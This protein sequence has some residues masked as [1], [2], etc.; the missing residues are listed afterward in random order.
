MTRKE[1]IELAE[2]ETKEKVVG[3][4][5]YRQCYVFNTNVSIVSATT[6]GFYLNKE[7]GKCGWIN[8]GDEVLDNEGKNLVDFSEMIDIFDDISTNSNKESKRR[9]KD[10]SKQG[11]KE[12]LRKAAS[13]AAKGTQAAINKTVE[14][15]EKTKRAIMR[16]MDVNG[17]GHVDSTD[18]ILMAMQVKGV[19][20]SRE[21]FLRK[22]LS[23]KYT[24][25]VVNK[26]IETTPAQAGI[27][28]EEVDRIADE[29]IK[30]ERN[31]VSGISAAL[32][33][34]GGVAMVA[35]IPADIAQYYGYMLRAAQKLMYLYGFPELIESEGDVNLDTGTINSLTACLA[36]MNGVAGANNFIKGMSKALA[37]GVEKKLLN[38]ALT[39][40][41]IYPLVKN[42]AKWF[43]VKMTKDVFAGFFKKAIPVV[44][45][46]IGGGL[47]FATFKPCCY[48]LKDALMDTMLSNPENHVAT[49]EENA[50]FEAIKKGVVID[51]DADDIRP[52]EE[53]DE[54]DELKEDDFEPISSWNHT[55]E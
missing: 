40:G 5:E 33:A 44:G 32:G 36:V 20:I 22:E 9:G 43:G 2:K 37:V 19:R 50:V 15:S 1:A 11:V 28:N 42:T 34:P 7:S 49:E 26:A 27:T 13:K 24:E 29:V 4:I 16:K 10:M 46:V 3:G 55:E 48:R 30:F 31:A 35:T 52:I 12:N 41:A 47:T 45:G 25:D 21:Q 51:L 8:Y 14:V 18:I 39:K 17:D 53:P 6:C 23:L 38:A 54:E